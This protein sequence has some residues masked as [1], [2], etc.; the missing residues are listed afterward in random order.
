MVTRDRARRIL[1]TPHTRQCERLVHDWF[2]AQAV[3]VPAMKPTSCRASLLAV[4]ALALAAVAGHAAADTDAR[5][6]REGVER[7]DYVTLESILAAAE[8]RHPG[9]V[10]SV[11]LDDD[12]YEVEILRADGTVV[13]LEYDARTGRLLDEE[14]EDD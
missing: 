1:P 5:R 14:F 6:A 2:S 4:A 11:D 7:G 8:L 12:E 9:R 13:E 3:T 10:V